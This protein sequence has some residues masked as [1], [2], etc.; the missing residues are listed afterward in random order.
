MNID[1]LDTA[2][3]EWSAFQSSVEKHSMILVMRH[4]GIDVVN[5]H[6]RSLW[7]D[8][9]GQQQELIGVCGDVCISIALAPESVLQVR[10][11]VNQWKKILKGSAA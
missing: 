11:F 2:G 3:N 10:R 8:K 5:T 9:T 4:N 1:F 7:M 6:A